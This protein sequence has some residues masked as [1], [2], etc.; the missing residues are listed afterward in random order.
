[1]II[2]VSKKSRT[3]TFASCGVAT[4][5]LKFSTAIKRYHFDESIRNVFIFWPLSLAALVDICHFILFET[6][7]ETKSFFVTNGKSLKPRCHTPL[8][9]KQSTVYLCRPILYVNQINRKLV[10]GNFPIK[11]LDMIELQLL[12][13]LEWVFTPL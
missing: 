3:Q 4:T 11:I 8:S 1:M 7:T 10:F 13:R 12:R 9:S 2:A 6:Y 5:H